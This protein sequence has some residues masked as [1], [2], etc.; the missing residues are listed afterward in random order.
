MNFLQSVCLS[1]FSTPVEN[2]AVYQT[3][4]RVKPAVIVEFGIQRG[5]RS[6]NILELA[7]RYR[8]PSEI[9]YCCVDPFE[10]R[11]VEDGPGL[12]LRKA[13]RMMVKTGVRIQA[14]PG[15]PETGLRQ[16]IGTVE[17]IDLLV[18][19]TPSTDWAFSSG[20]VLADLLSPRGIVLIGCS[21]PSGKP[22]ELA[23]YTA[24]QLRRPGAPHRRVA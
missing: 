2:R 14:I 1:Y 9:R 18:V 6:G 22:F 11:A 5:V 12:S 15:M 4:C 8:K 7:K 10:G 3:V 21:T 16:I 19:A 24:E 17:S 13:Y 20:A 23:A